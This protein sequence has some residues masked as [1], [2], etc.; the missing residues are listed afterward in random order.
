MATILKFTNNNFNFTLAYPVVKMN[1][2]NFKNKN[3]TFN[4]RSPLQQDKRM[5]LPFNYTSDPFNILFNNANK[6]VQNSAVYFNCT[7]QQ[8]LRLEVYKTTSSGQYSGDIF[9]VSLQIY[10]ED[11]WIYAFS[12]RSFLSS[13]LFNIR[14][15]QELPDTKIVQFAVKGILVIDEYNQIIGN[16][17]NCYGTYHTT[18]FNY[19]E[20]VRE[21]VTS[22]VY[23]DKDPASYPYYSITRSTWLSF[24]QIENLA[25]DGENFITIPYLNVANSDEARQEVYNAFI[26]NVSLPQYPNNED[27]QGSNPNGKD[28]E[29]EQP[30]GTT[31]YDPTNKDPSTADNTSDNINTP[32][33]PAQGVTNT[34]F[35]TIYNPS[36][37]EI[38][39]LASFMWSA[40]IADLL[41]KVFN[42]P[43]DAIIGLKL[44][45]APVTTANRQT[46]WLG[47]TETKTSALRVTQQFTDFDCGSLN[48]E[49]YFQSFLDYAPYTKVGI[50][51]PFIGY[52]ELNVDEVMNS[53]LSLTYRID[54]YSGSCIAFIKVTKTIGSTNLNSILYQ[55][56]GNCAMEI[57]FTSLNLQ[58][59]INSV[60]GVASAVTQTITAGQAVI[61][62]PQPG[63]YSK[64]TKQ[65]WASVNKNFEHSLARLGNSGLDLISTKP[66]ISRTGSLAGAN[67]SMAVKQ[68][69][70]VIER[71]MQQMP[72]DYAHFMGI[73]LNL[74]K[75]LSSMTGF[76]V[77]SDIQFSSNIATD[78]E[79]A[80][81][82][83]LL[84]Q[85]VII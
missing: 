38:Q 23:T 84:K 58:Q 29:T 24:Q 55:F 12:N 83:G 36:I 82:V 22:S 61:G 47:M 46:I 7:T 15:P 20:Y 67:A 25:V 76:T 10:S 31:D 70:L 77:I 63:E 43:T 54:A 48:V 19:I 5:S 17:G 13:P 69:Y 6:F 79:H 62:T 21:N 80:I 34:G 16:I 14:R 37:T 68:P 32:N 75:R 33:R 35:V 45:Y 81:V 18:P 74:T 3:G 53:T 11:K 49:E 64:T 30:N 9:E 59:Y 85:G 8:N 78:E 50:Y 65:E 60:L 71:P 1:C 39:S 40:E 51:L 72:T 41:K 4:Y 66:R 2:S 73:P 52:R 28:P 44:L 56:D 57:P 27:D 42:E 26:N